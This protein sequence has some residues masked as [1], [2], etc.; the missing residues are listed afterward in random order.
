MKDT[1]SAAAQLIHGDGGIFTETLW[2]G[3]CT[4]GSPA[5][6]ALGP[7][8]MTLRA[9]ARGAYPGV[10]DRNR[11][12]PRHCGDVLLLMTDLHMCANLHDIDRV[13]DYGTVMQVTP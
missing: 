9:M 2:T 13:M 12:F 6:P 7:Q 4:V 8:R 11:H 10:W 5:G 1:L 3:D